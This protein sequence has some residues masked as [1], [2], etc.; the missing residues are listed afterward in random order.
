MRGI[1]E[2]SL[3]QGGWVCQRCNKFTTSHNPRYK[4]CLQGYDHIYFAG[5]RTITTI[6]KDI[7]KKVRDFIAKAKQ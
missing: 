6:P 7:I 4:G 2:Y 3:R 5:Q 1:G